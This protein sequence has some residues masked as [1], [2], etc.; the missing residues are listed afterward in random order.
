MQRPKSLVL[1]TPTKLLSLEEAQA[2]RNT[3]YSESDE[4]PK[5][6]EVGGGPAALPKQYHTVLD[7]PGP[8]ERYVVLFYI[9]LLWLITSQKSIPTKYLSGD[10][11]FYYQFLVEFSPTFEIFKKTKQN[12]Q[13]QKQKIRKIKK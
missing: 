4:K 7:F 1:S 5:F 3:L 13:T 9:A 6:I 10:S 2:T 12:K 11:S 8:R